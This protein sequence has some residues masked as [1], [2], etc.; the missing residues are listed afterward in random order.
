[1][2]RLQTTNGTLFSGTQ[3]TTK[4]ELI[5]H[6]G[7]VKKLLNIYNKTV[8]KTDI[9]IIV[10]GSTLSTNDI[11]FYLAQK[12]RQTGSCRLRFSFKMTKDNEKLCSLTCGNKNVRK[13]SDDAWDFCIAS[14]VPLY[15]EIQYFEIQVTQSSNANDGN[16]IGVTSDINEAL[17]TLGYVN[18]ETTC[19]L[20]DSRTGN[21]LSQTHVYPEM[22]A[23]TQHCDV[24]SVIV[25]RREDRILFYLNGKFVAFGC[26]KPSQFKELYVF[27]STYHQGTMFTETEK[28]QYSEL[29]KPELPATK[30][31]LKENQF[32]KYYHYHKGAK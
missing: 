1:M 2:K 28:Y 27:V 11:Y 10:H 17:M 3:T 6:T 16:Y 12:M 19:A 7:N 25:D 21:F 13:T 23:C 32:M 15:R 14:D 31:E 29:E 5:L 24:I 8:M 22:D 9:S 20:Y 4:I 26:K 18:T 30:P